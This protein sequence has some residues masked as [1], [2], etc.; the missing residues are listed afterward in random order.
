MDFSTLMARVMAILSKPKTEWAVIA[1]ESTSTGALYSKYIVWLA[2][3]PPVF[4]FIKGSLMGYAGIGSGI[5]RMILTYAMVLILVYVVALIVN[6]L[7]GSFDAQ[8]SQIQALKTVAYAY[9]A[10]WIAGAAVIIPGLGVLIA[11]AG[12]IYSIYLLYLGLPHTMKCPR[13]K[14]GGYTAVTVIITL[15]LGMVLGWLIIGSM[16]ASG[17]H[18][19]SG[20]FGAAGSD[21]AHFDKDSRLGKLQ[22]MSERMQEAGK[23]IEAAQKS[24]D[25]KAG[26]EALGTMMAAMSGSKKPVEALSTDQIKSFLPESVNGLDRTSISAERNMAMGMQIAQARAEYTSKAD[27][28]GSRGRQRLRLEV[29]DSGGAKA[30]LGMAGMFGHE[31]E[32]Q[33]ENG[34][35]RSY[36]KDGQMFE[37]KW[38]G[39]YK[40]GKYAVVI[41]GRFKVEANGD[42]DSFEDLKRA[43]ASVDLQ[44]LASLKDSGVTQ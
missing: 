25:S 11:L 30:I 27:D 2:A 34:F 26:N 20:M 44:R 9:T 7:A 38:D 31:S 14:A 6:A 15:L 3:I 40:R 22:A 5:G 32:K 41:G 39:K 12:S 35:E 28:D 24:G 13:E 17:A 18:M 42:A 4:G 10:A 23:K 16:F 43:V 8:K 37:E 19:S 33:T 1:G 36:S 29:M 21:S